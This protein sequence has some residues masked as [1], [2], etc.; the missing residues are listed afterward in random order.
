M[1]DW[2]RRKR[3]FALAFSLIALLVIGGLA[4]LTAQALHMERAADQSE[5]QR[6]VAEE[7]RQREKDFD[8]RLQLAMMLLESR[9]LP[10]LVQEETRPFTHYLPVIASSTSP[11]RAEGDREKPVLQPSPLLAANQP[12]WILLHFQ[13]AD[14]ES[15][16][17]PEL[18]SDKLRASLMRLGIE[19]PHDHTEQ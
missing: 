13:S 7:R 12:D 10:A 3:R 19:L 5:R 14:A 9:V 2:L 11:S 1:T 4:W 6:R 15:W 18:P 17:A 16:Q 8:H